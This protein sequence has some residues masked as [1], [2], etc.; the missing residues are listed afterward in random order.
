MNEKAVVAKNV[1]RQLI[2]GEYNTT[3][4]VKYYEACENVLRFRNQGDNQGDRL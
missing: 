1:L 2:S 4:Q 3:R